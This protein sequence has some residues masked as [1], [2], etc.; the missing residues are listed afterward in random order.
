MKSSDRRVKKRRK[1][2]AVTPRMLRWI[3]R[4]LRPEASHDDAATWLALTLGYFFLLRSSEYV[5]SDI[6]SA[7]AVHCLRGAD[8]TAQLRDLLFDGANSFAL[9]FV[10]LGVEGLGFRR[11]ALRDV[12]RHELPL[13]LHVVHIPNVSLCSWLD[14]SL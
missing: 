2:R 6:P 4:G 1:R 13:R 10:G 5:E 11:H 3:F 14:M 12:Y 9:F 7:G 8:I